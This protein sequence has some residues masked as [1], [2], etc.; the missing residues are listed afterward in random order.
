[1]AQIKW[2]TK[3][4]VFPRDK[5]KVY[6]SC[7]PRDY[8]S[9]FSTIT[10]EILQYC[11]CAIYYY[12][13]EP[14]HDEAYYTNLEQMQLVVI[15]VTTNLLQMPSRAM[16]TE[17]SF[18]LSHHIP[19]LPLMQES[20][21]EER[22]ALKFGNL[23]Y[24]MKNVQDV[25]AIPYEEKLKMYL[26]AVLLNDEMTE[27]VRTAFDAWIFLSYR[28]KDRKAAQELMKLIH[29]DPRCRD[30]AIWYDEFLTPGEDFSEAIH[31]MLCESDLFVMTVTP[32]L[33]EAQNYVIAEEFPRAKQAGKTILSA[34]M[35]KT[36]P[37]VLNRC[38]PGI[39]VPL[40]PHTNGEVTGAIADALSAIALREND[41]DVKHNFFIGLAY[42]SG[43]YVE[44]DHPRALQLITDAAE[45]GLNEAVEKLIAM[46][47][48]G[49]GVQRNYRTAVQWAEKLSDKAR[50]EY[51]STPC[52]QTE[53]R[54]LQKLWDLTDKWMK[55][56]EWYTAEKTCKELLALAEKRMQK[57]DSYQT[58]DV[59]LSVCD[60][61]ATICQR[62][63]EY[64]QV[65]LDDIF[66]LEPVTDGDPQPGEDCAIG[67]RKK[68]CEIS[69]IQAQSG[70]PHDLLVLAFDYRRLGDTYS[71]Y[72]AQCYAGKRKSQRAKAKEWYEKSWQIMKRLPERDDYA[73]LN[74]WTGIYH[75]MGDVCWYENRDEEALQW[76]EKS[77]KACRRWEN[78]GSDDILAMLA[79][80]YRRIGNVYKYQ[81]NLDEAEMQYNKALEISQK[82]AEKGTI[83]GLRQM[84]N[85]YEKLESI[86]EK[87]EDF[88]K[89]KQHYAVKLSL[90]Q[91]LDDS[92]NKKRESFLYWYSREMAEICKKL[93][94][95]DGQI[96][97]QV[98]A[99]Q[100]E[101]RDA[102]QKSAQYYLNYSQ[103]YPMEFRPDLL[104][105]V[106]VCRTVEELYKKKGDMEN[107][108]KW[109]RRR[110]EELRRYPMTAKTPPRELM[111]ACRS[112][113]MEFRDLPMLEEA[114]DCAE[115]L[116]K[117]NPQKY[118]SSVTEMKTWIRVLQMPQA[119]NATQNELWSIYVKENPD[120]AKTLTSDYVCKQKMKS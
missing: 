101:L 82:I 45:A 71:G 56:E 81:D 87:R 53:E 52:P 74:Y 116:A 77:L 31:K 94:D 20:G 9:C 43:L 64:I 105:H 112:Y 63:N 17:L 32:N 99:A 33:T 120:I 70:K 66:F 85:S 86:W 2:K 38:F 41:T 72:A 60:K 113:G 65:N 109:W 5:A 73:H 10:D 21:L 76:Y 115:F 1:M 69:E 16:E 75:A 35:E 50:A 14:E 28:K 40:N 39:P 119:K 118:Q 8:A 79:N 67:W 47:E 103:N 95:L 96:H 108:G 36:D 88:Q 4:G 12:E 68:C 57:N 59:Y 92:G 23:Q 22:Y 98:Q 89:L 25:T 55:I 46:Y 58:R 15:P 19:V 80:C 7:H 37:D 90:Q 54:L 107:A 84:I 62:L 102:D 106:Q 27:K 26:D 11:N 61:R 48:S 114:L 83:L 3:D 110:I 51:E 44:K 78:T 34:E 49:E 24:L 29:S 111:I 13:V 97:W 42:L 18:A 6:F 93:D 30:I 100:E 117:L 91:Q 104:N